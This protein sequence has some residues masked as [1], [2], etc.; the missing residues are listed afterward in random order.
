MTIRPESNNDPAHLP[1][2]R[3]RIALLSYR[4]NPYSGG[5]G[6]YVRHLSRALVEAGHQVDV[7]SGE[8]YPDLDPRVGLIPLPGMNFYAYARP[9]QAIRERGLRSWSDVR[10]WL[11][12]NS[13]GFPEP[14]A[15][16]RRAARYLALQG[17]SYD[18]I[19]DNQSLSYGLLQL[20]RSGR[21]VVATMHHPITRDL[22]FALESEPNWG[23]RL[24][25]RRWHGFLKMQKKVAPRLPKIIAVSEASKR[26][27]QQDF[28]V[29]PGRVEVVHNGVD[30]ATFAPSPQ[31]KPEPC[32]IMATASADVP[33]KGLH[34]LLQAVASLV[35]ELPDISLTVLGKP[36]SN[37]PTTRLI[38]ELGLQDRIRF[39]SGLTDREIALAYA[40]SSLAVVPSLYEGFG[41]PAAE[42][43]A[44]AKPVVATTGGAL[45][46]VVG[47]AGELVPPGDAASL[48][49][50]IRG[51][52]T[53]PERA[54]ELGRLARGRMERSFTWSRAAHGTLQAY[55]RLLAAF[56]PP[57]RP[58]FSLT[59]RPRPAS[60]GTVC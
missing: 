4:S 7:I 39:L 53:D 34:V 50:A 9:S 17:R 42:A 19:H 45:P 3:L 56:Q 25:L 41:L 60:R 46:E 51:L 18:I 1:E 47:P 58:G 38:S 6:I 20:M 8:P 21:P 54:G 57:A 29:D 24:L 13:G 22:R 31:I 55:G 27:I 43:M 30:T 26:D 36:K 35:P 33:L 32:R 10:E 59:R 49:A 40:A 15:F 37:G 16:G 44:C 14:E 2:R 11:S 28:R 48:A 5:Q 52:L 12:Y 23:L